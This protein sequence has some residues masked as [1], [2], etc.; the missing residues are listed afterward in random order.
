M[1]YSVNL[2]NRTDIRSILPKARAVNTSMKS[3]ALFNKG[4]CCAYV[5]Y[6]RSLE[7]VERERERERKKD[8]KRELSFSV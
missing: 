8:R 3:A 2:E 4:Y 1:C 7:R 5:S 6:M